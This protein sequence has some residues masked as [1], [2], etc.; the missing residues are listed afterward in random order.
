MK[1][2]EFIIDGDIYLKKNPKVTDYSNLAEELKEVITDI[3]YD[4]SKEN[5]DFSRST[6]LDGYK[7][8]LDRVE[9]HNGK[10]SY[11]DNIYFW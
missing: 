2:V 9:F 3:E 7:H 11:V 8:L 10:L 6:K 1:N 5:P 4:I